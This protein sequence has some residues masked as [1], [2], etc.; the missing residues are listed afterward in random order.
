MLFNIT[1]GSRSTYM[2]FFC[3]FRNGKLLFSQYETLDSNKSFKLNSST[4]AEKMYVF[5]KSN[6]LN[7]QSP[8]ILMNACNIPQKSPPS[9]VVDLIMRPDEIS[10]VNNTINLGSRRVVMLMNCYGNISQFI[11]NTTNLGTNVINLKK[12]D[13]ACSYIGLQLDLVSLNKIIEYFAYTPIIINESKYAP[14]AYFFIVVF[15]LI[16]F[17]IIIIV[18]VAAIAAM[19]KSGKEDKGSKKSKRSQVITNE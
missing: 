11:N 6:S 18:F 9:Q 1:N 8:F 2:Y 14:F 7:F 10:V 15:F 5:A 17:I 16:I 4:N 3:F 13:I 12:E 19:Q